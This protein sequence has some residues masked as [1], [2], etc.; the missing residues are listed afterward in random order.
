MKSWMFRAI[1]GALVAPSISIGAG[2]VWPGVVMLV[3]FAAVACAVFVYQRR[4]QF[5]FAG[6]TVRDAGDSRVRMDLRASVAV[7]TLAAVSMCVLTGCTAKQKQTTVQIIQQINTHIPEVVAAADTVAA[8]IA[9][10]TPAEAALIAVCDGGFDAAAKTLQALT[11]AYLANPSASILQQIQD[12]INSLEAAINTATLN[13]FGIKNTVSQNLALAA[14]K[15]LLTVV[16]VVFGLIS[17]TETTAQLQALAATGTMH[18]AELRPYMDEH[19]LERFA[20]EREIVNTVPQKTED[21]RHASVMAHLD[22]EA[23]AIA[24]MRDGDL[25]FQKQYALE[26]KKADEAQLYKVNSDNNDI[27]TSN[28]NR[29]QGD[30]G[31]TPLETLNS[32]GAVRANAMIE[33]S[34]ELSA[35]RIQ[36]TRQES[37]EIIKLRQQ[38]TNAGLKGEQLFEA[39]RLQAIAEFEQ[40]YDASQAAIDAINLRYH[41][42]EMQ[43]LQEQS[44]AVARRAREAGVAGQKGIAGIV[45][46]GQNRQ[47]DITSDLKAGKYFGTGVQQATAAQYDRM[48][49]ERETDAQIVEA[50]QRFSDSIDDIAATSTERQVQGFARIRAEG[51]K[52]LQDLKRRFDDTYGHL[53]LA[54]PAQAKL[55]A[56]GQTDLNRGRA[57]INSNTNS[58]ITDLA[59]KNADETARLEAEAYEKSLP[60]I[61][62]HE[63]QIRDQYNERHASYVRMLQAN[64]ISREDYSRREAAAQREMNAELDAAARAERDRIAGE[65]EP[66]FRNPLQAMENFGEKQAAKYAATLVM[67]YNGGHAVDGSTGKHASLLDSMMHLGGH[68]HTGHTANAP[69]TAHEV[70]T[71]TITATYVI[72]NGSA[73]GASTTAASSGG[74]AIYSSSGTPVAMASPSLASFTGGSSASGGVADDINSGLAGSNNAIQLG[75]QVFGGS[76]APGAS[77][78]SI[79]DNINSGLAGA[80]NGIKLGKQLFGKDGLNMPQVSKA[81]GRASKLMNAAA[82]VVGAG[83]GMFSAIESNGGVGGALTGAMSGMKL[84]A[85]VAGPMGA[86]VG[87]AAGAILGFIG[88]G[89]ASKAERYY[90]YQVKPHI[91]QDVTAFG[92]GEMDYQSAEDDLNKLNKDAR[93]QTKQWGMG[94][95]GVWDNKINPDIMAAIKNIEREQKAGRSQ[96]GMSAAQFHSGGTVMG[97]G[98]FATSPTE[99]FAHLKVGETVMHERAT[100]THGD[101][102]DMML[103][104]AS[105]D[106]MASYYGG[107]AA[108]MASAYTAAMKQSAF[109]GS[110]HTFNTGDTYHISAIDSKSFHDAL[111]ANKHS[112]RKANALSYG[113]NSGGADLV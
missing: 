109:G 104:G 55:Y 52:A 39:Q 97:F 5:A 21:E 2:R 51:D 63:Q 36:F 84:G 31:Y 16:T 57:A 89:G 13:A 65:L 79:S 101:A 20:R 78:A 37:D 62:Q 41:N 85:M 59:A 94:G 61:M 82:P 47:A 75:N 113:E 19:E 26:Q 86:A 44:D 87:A 24:T 90:Q 81:M 25:K 68:K 96:Y 4:S 32:Q 46:R 11:A 53:N 99:G 38:A 66:F 28:G 69:A 15:G 7:L 92:M 17:Q 1:G 105:R 77:G 100:A 8:T 6:A 34:A 67:R 73:S 56:Q 60:Q 3:A 110:G 58:Q 103:A 49:A 98:D 50:R 102:L 22:A 70:E 43:R 23:K 33:A 42:E 30:K 27:R 12:A 48:S 10:L 72:L 91:T 74:A 107:G 35:K 108:A 9:A 93:N 106:Q 111:I 29:K 80:D 64:Q 83:M 95:K 112:V 45:L 76:T 14:L 54:D 18:L 40:K 71:V 88:I